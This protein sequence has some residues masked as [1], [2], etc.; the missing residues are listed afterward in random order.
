MTLTQELELRR[1]ELSDE[2]VSRFRSRH[3]VVATL[4]GSLLPLAV[5][6]LVVSVWSDQVSAIDQILPALVLLLVSGTIAADAL[7]GDFDPF[8]PKLPALVMMG[9]LFGARPI[10]MVATDQFSV[11]GIDMRPQFTSVALMGLVSTLAFIVGTAAG[12]SR[13]PRGDRERV[14]TSRGVLPAVLLALLGLALFGMNILRQ[15]G[16][17]GRASPFWPQAGPQPLSPISRIPRSTCRP[18]LCCSP[19]GRS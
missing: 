8:A 15:G 12:T 19:W 4:V 17:S 3:Q 18:R 9:I 13:Q 10:Y 7:R 2:G 1:A 5:L 16:N 11:Y 6:A 14:L